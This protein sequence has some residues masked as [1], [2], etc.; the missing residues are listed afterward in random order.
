MTFVT[1]ARLLHLARLA[2]RGLF[3]AGALSIW[4]RWAFGQVEALGGLCWGCRTSCNARGD[5]LDDCAA[6]QGGLR[7]VYGVFFG[8]S[9]S[10]ATDGDKDVLNLLETR[11]G[12]QTDDLE[13]SLRSYRMTGSNFVFQQLLV[14]KSKKPGTFAQNSG[15]NSS[16]FSTK[17]DFDTAKVDAVNKLVLDFPSYLKLLKEPI[18]KDGWK[19]WGFV[20]QPKCPTVTPPSIVSQSVTPL[21][22]TTKVRTPSAPSKDST[23]EVPSSMF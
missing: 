14:A 22:P 4:L 19:V 9:L 11:Y 10:L 17:E 1:I 23:E 20:K 6:P 2:D 3:Q 8:V 18:G 15:G 16:C 7:L 5:K 13:R 12:N 21:Q